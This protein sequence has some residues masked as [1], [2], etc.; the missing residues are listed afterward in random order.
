MRCLARFSL[1]T[2]AFLIHINDL[3][4]C[5]QNSTPRIYSDDTNIITSDKSLIKVIR[6]TNN[7]LS[8]IKQLLLANKLSFNAAKTEHMF[9]G[10]DYDLNKIK[11]TSQIHIEG[12]VLTLSCPRRLPLTSK[13]DW[14]K[15]G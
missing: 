14:R 5:L 7:G 1:R 15:P 9:I 10:L 6:L 13:I 2:T 11:I 4:N 8:S 12:H 3:P